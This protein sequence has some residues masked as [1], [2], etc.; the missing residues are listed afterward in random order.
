[1]VDRV[2]SVVG[3]A[4]RSPAYPSSIYERQRFF[5]NSCQRI[6]LYTY[7]LETDVDMKDVE[8]KDI[9]RISA[10]DGTKRTPTAVTYG[11]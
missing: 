6:F 4:L 5:L 10:V 3:L 7:A 11:N 8:Q 9:H 1:M 2:M